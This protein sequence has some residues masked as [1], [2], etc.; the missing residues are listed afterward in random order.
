MC[1]F[2]LCFILER[3]H[4]V[5]EN[6]KRLHDDDPCQLIAGHFGRSKWGHYGIHEWINGSFWR[7]SLLLVQQQRI[8]ATWW[9]KHLVVLHLHGEVIQ[10]W[11]I[12]QLGGST[13]L[14]KY[15]W[16]YECIVVSHDAAIS[17]TL[18]PRLYRKD[19]AWFGKK[20]VLL[21]NPV[22]QMLQDYSKHQ[23]CF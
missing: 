1:F 2:F 14:G 3:V 19:F 10:F 7:T 23:W 22:P 4:H 6:R 20:M 5:T 15:G 16:Y 9:C 11:R 21:I 12:F 13:F 8:E 18:P 17:M